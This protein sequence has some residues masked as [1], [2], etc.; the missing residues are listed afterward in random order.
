MDHLRPVTSSR[1]VTWMPVRRTSPW[2]PSAPGRRTF[3]TRLTRV[4]PRTQRLQVAHAVVAARHDAA[5]LRGRRPAP[6][7]RAP[8]DGNAHEVIAPQHTSTQRTPVGWQPGPT[9]T[10]IPGHTAPVG[11]QNMFCQGPA[12]VT[13]RS[14]CYISA[15]MQSWERDAASHVSPSVAVRRHTST[16]GDERRRAFRRP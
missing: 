11:G 3:S 14:R 16:S 4:M 15:L 12:R 7:A 13:G 6:C 1:Q 8:Q 9:V 10:A 5:H 2:H